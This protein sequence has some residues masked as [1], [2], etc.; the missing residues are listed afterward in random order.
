[1]QGYGIQ[2]L[3]T[4]SLLMG[5]WRINLEIDQEPHYLQAVWRLDSITRLIQQALPKVVWLT[6]QISD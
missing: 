3:K 4:L 1:M 5:N 6:R 2:R